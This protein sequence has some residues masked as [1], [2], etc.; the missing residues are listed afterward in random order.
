[1]QRRRKTTILS[2][3]YLYLSQDLKIEEIFQV[4]L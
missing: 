1:M 2:F 3:A 4:K